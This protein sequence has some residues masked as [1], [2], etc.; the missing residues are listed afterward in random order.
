[1]YTRLREW[2]EAHPKAKF[3]EIAKEVGEERKRLKGGLLSEM[4]VTDEGTQQVDAARI[5]SPAG[6]GT[7][8]FA[9]NILCLSIRL[10]RMAG[11]PMISLL[12]QAHTPSRAGHCERQSPG[13]PE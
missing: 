10:F 11:V 9:W 6:M 12:R 5:R 4:A 1:M 3:D 2:R 13:W 7:D 8:G